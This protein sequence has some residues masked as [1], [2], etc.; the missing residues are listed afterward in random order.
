MYYSGHF[1]GELKVNDSVLQT[2]EGAEDIFLVKTNSSGK[3]VYSKSFGSKN[4]DYAIRDGLNFFDNNLYFGA[5]ITDAVAFQSFSVQPYS[6]TIVNMQT[7]CIMKLDTSGNV[8]WVNKQ[9]FTLL[10]ISFML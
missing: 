4:P 7:G 8:K 2:G 1:R 10:M 6:N 5:Q 9:K 3:A